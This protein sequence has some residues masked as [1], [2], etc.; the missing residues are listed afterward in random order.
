MYF[1][2]SKSGTALQ[3]KYISTFISPV[4]PSPCLD[5]MTGNPFLSFPFLISTKITAAFLST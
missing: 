4:F 5:L 2:N 1:Q 3:C